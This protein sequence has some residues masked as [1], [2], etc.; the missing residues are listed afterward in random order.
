M[1]KPVPIAD[2]VR[3]VMQAAGNA[4]LLDGHYCG[5][6]QLPDAVLSKPGAGHHR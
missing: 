1:E 3:N 5:V 4:N 6:K 2:F